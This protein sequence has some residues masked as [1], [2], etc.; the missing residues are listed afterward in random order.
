MFFL[1]LGKQ[2]VDFW[3]SFGQDF[4]YSSPQPTT[5]TQLVWKSSVEIGMYLAVN[6]TKIYVTA[7]YSPAGN[8]KGRFGENV[9]PVIQQQQQKRV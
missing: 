7:F 1:V 5:F 2:I 6:G 8:V 4:N 3:Y 9:S